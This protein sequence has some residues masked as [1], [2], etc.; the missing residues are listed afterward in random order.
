MWKFTVMKKRIWFV[1][2]LT[3][4]ILLGFFLT[5]IAADDKTITWSSAFSFLGVTV[6]YVLLLR[7]FS[8]N[9]MKSKL[10]IRDGRHVDNFSSV[11]LKLSTHN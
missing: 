11:E 2:S 1:V 9:Y 5:D 7:L 6:G 3:S 4:A 8:T 10:G